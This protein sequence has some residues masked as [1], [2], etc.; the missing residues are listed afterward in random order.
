MKSS[1]YEP[2]LISHRAALSALTDL[3]NNSEGMHKKNGLP[4]CDRVWEG[5]GVRGGAVAESFF[6]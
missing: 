4:S 5:A 6:S 2:G 3:C 1:T